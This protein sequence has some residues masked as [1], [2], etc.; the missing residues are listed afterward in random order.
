MEEPLVRGDFLA[1]QRWCQPSE[2]VAPPPAAVSAP[3]FIQGAP[4]KGVDPPKVSYLEAQLVRGIHGRLERLRPVGTPISEE[5]KPTETTGRMFLRYD[6]RSPEAASAN[7]LYVPHPAEGEI[8]HDEC[9]TVDL[10]TVYHI[11]ND[12]MCRTLCIHV[13]RTEEVRQSFLFI[14][15]DFAVCTDSL[16][17][18]LWKCARQ[19]PPA[20][21]KS[22][23]TAEVPGQG[24]P[25]SWPSRRLRASSSLEGIP[26]ERERYLNYLAAILPSSGSCRTPN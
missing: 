4:C 1:A 20:A 3:V 12:D 24:A 21:T 13:G 25:K 26:S 9:I 14:L 10:S 6:Q 2:G 5:D 8:K 22:A 16:A 11:E 19:A 7:L 23:K 18:A 17:R 15:Q